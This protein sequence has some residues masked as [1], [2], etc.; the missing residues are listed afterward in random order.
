MILICIAAVGYLVACVAFGPL[1]AT[2]WFVFV[3]LMG[4]AGSK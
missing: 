4:Y 3:A 1:A 2:G